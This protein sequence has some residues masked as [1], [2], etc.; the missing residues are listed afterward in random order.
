[1][2]LD[3]LKS[4]WQ[5]Q[6]SVRKAAGD[7]TAA[8]AATA[9]STAEEGRAAAVAAAAASQQQCSRLSE[10]LQARICNSRESSD[11]DEMALYVEALL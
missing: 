7:R 1:M 6:H 9:Q 8:A 3:D 5:K 11:V 4:E 2:Q 10:Q